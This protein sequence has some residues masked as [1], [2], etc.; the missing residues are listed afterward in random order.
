MIPSWTCENTSPGLSQ[1]FPYLPLGKCV[2]RGGTPGKEAGLLP[3]W[4]SLHMETWVRQSTTLETW[5]RQSST[6]ETWVR[7]SST[8]ETWVRWSTTETR[9]H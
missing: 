3:S 1:T 2:L 5:V 4:S 8:V 7:Q 6:L 9:V